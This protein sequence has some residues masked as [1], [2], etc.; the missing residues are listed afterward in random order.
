[1]GVHRLAVAE[2]TVV[3]VLGEKPSDRSGDGVPIGA[4][5]GRRVVGPEETENRQ[6]GNGGIGPDAG[7]AAAFSAGIIEVAAAPATVVALVR[8]QPREG[9]LHSLFGLRV[10]AALLENA[11]AELGRALGIRVRGRHHLGGDTEVGGDRRWWIG[12][13][14]GCGRARRS[15][16][17]VPP[18][19]SSDSQGCAVRGGGAIRAEHA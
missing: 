11:L 16:W 9:P 10:A 8:R 3:G 12:E 7:F 1:M 19:Q 17:S 4:V 6:A 15:G 13:I 5:F 14:A 2:F 18:R